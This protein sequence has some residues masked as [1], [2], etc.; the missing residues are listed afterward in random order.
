MMQTELP[1][2][3]EISAPKPAQ[4][5]KSDDY[6][7]DI[8]VLKR[9]FDD[10]RTMLAESRIDAEISRDYYDGPK[11]ITP[12]MLQALRDRKQPEVWDNC[13]RGAVDGI[14]GIIDS[15]KVDPRAFP[16]EPG[17][18]DAADVASDT[19]RYTAEKNHFSAIKADVLEEGLV[20]GCG[21][22]IIEGAPDQDVSLTQ[23]RW[24]EFFYDPRSR[25]AN[26]SDARYLGIAKW[27][28]AD[29]LAAVFPQ[30]A[31][32]F[33]SFASGVGD[34]AG[35]GV[36]DITWED[37]PEDGAAWLDNGR[38]R[39]MVVE[40]YHQWKN[41]WYRSVFCA[42]GI[43][44]HGVSP[45][46]DDAGNPKC[47]I[48][49]WCAYVSRDNRRYGVVRDLRPMQDEVNMRRQKVL[50]ELNV[51]Q[52]Q[53]VTPDAP[54]VSVDTVRM[55]AARPDGVI[56][57]GWNI[58]DRKDVVQG[59]LELLS[60]AKASIVRMSPNP[61]LMGR[62]PAS[63]SGRSDQIRQA[64]GM[65]ELQRVLGRFA[66]WELRV[67]KAMWA[68]QRQFWSAPK[69]VRVTGD[70]MAPKYIQINEVV[71][72]GVPA[73][74]PQ[75]GQPQTDQNGQPIWQQPPQVK[76][77][78]AEMDVD[79]I[80]DTVPDTASLQQEVWQEL[81][82]LIAGNPA[83]AQQVPFTL[84]VEMSPLPRKQQ[85][86]KQIEAAN[87]AGAV[88]RQSQEQEKAQAQMTEQAHRESQ[89]VLNFAKAKN[90]LIEGI[91][92]ALTAHMSANQA[93]LFEAQF[94]GGIPNVP[95]GAAPTGP[96][97]APPIAPPAAPGPAPT[98]P[99]TMPAAQ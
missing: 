88:Q 65:Q 56:P 47:A 52:V 11:Q 34:A 99:Q 64:A 38:R 36:G 84:A 96:M 76:N 74:D 48:E 90:E 94:T 44:E 53:M 71:A 22:V 43:L 32:E 27:M 55:E 97:V 17:D 80:I 63:A 83:Y 75:T 8:S 86:L 59:Q 15:N 29:A 82:R 14:V 39:V 25:K 91:A 41:T 73:I 31:T 72:P 81:V 87:Q 62:N 24:D 58:V 3:Q 19:L 28:Y 35:V 26:F 20:E 7:F 30:K 5:D 93:A 6:D 42:A 67:Y 37:K 33:Q 70:E 21:A 13:I 69:W 9:M 2:W 68:R 92:A 1:D 66:D 4:P 61:A 57:M 79:I 50:H 78:I 54:P 60:E 12:M 46:T 77:H 51:R 98:P 10:T 95:T 49:G 18:D 16:R 85:L 23:V 40:V 89:T 45:Y